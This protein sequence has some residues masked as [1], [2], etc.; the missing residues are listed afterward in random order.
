M[1]HMTQ[2]GPPLAVLAALSGACSRS[3]EARHTGSETGAADS[4]AM[5]ASPASAGTR[6]VSNVMIG[7]AVGPSNRITEPNF[8]FA[9]HDTVYVSVGTEGVGGDGML[10]AAWRSQSGEIVQQS[11][12]AVLVAPNNTVFQLSRPEGLRPGTYKVVIFLA[13]DSAD[14][15]VFVVK[16]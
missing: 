7:R 3:E 14:A 6:R 15:K 4:A 13:N 2:V 1:A 11:S 9:P 10:T 5:A 8:Q 12:E 16:K